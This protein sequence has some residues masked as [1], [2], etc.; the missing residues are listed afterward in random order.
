MNVRSIGVTFYPDGSVSSE[1]LLMNA[2]ATI[3][4]ARP[5]ASESIPGR[6]RTG[7]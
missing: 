1:M 6:C 3:N 7:R 5:A 2:L 4:Q